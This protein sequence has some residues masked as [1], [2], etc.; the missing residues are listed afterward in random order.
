MIISLVVAGFHFDLLAHAGGF[1]RDEVNLINVASRP[2]LGQMSL[3]SFPVGMPLL[4]K[5]WT[6]LGLAQS[7]ANLRLLG[8][9]IGLAA[10]ASLWI[11]SFAVCRAPPL[12]SLT[13]FALN[14]N[15][16]IF[17]DSVRSYGLG[18]LLIVLTG[19]AACAVLKRP[20]WSRTA[21]LAVIAVLSVQALFHNAILVGAIC[22][23]AMTVC[24]RRRNCLAAVRI[25]VAGIAAAVSL[26]PYLPHLFSGHD[27]MAVLRVGSSWTDVTT[28]L[29]VAVGSPV[30]P[31]ACVWASL[32]VAV[33]AIA[34]AT[35]FQKSPN[36][37]QS[38]SNAE[39]RLF[40]G[41][42]S[43]AAIAG[44]LG[45]LWLTG[46]PEEPWYFI[47]LMVLLATG[48]DAVFATLPDKM[49]NAILTGAAITFLISL[50]IDWHQMNFRFTNV[51]TLATDVTAE[52]SPDDYVVITPWFYGITFA[53]YYQGATPWTTVP[54]MAD[55]STHR[56]DLLR[57]Q[58]LTTNAIQPILG[59]ITATLRNGHRV[60]FLYP[61]KVMAN[62][63]EGVS[64]PQILPPPPLPRIGWSPD[65][66]VAMWT[67]QVVFLLVN[68]GREIRIVDAKQS[69]S[70][71]TEDMDLLVI[72]GW[73]DTP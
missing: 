45:F 70:S 55:H 29:M 52:A 26:L 46:L 43:L 2:S 40:A 64:K 35:G 31:F 19:A 47:S 8:I 51:D 7:D 15:V 67:S 63:R 62:L 60:W 4:V 22:L 56:Y 34:A 72:N 24:A 18:A 68:N 58:M 41:T 38:I 44:L 57:E 17:G 65:P 1:W 9:F 11:A 53:H 59:K 5:S 13:L 6:G 25:A 66:Y 20:C 37:G 54:P 71:I 27:A 10:I 42:T 49:K 28:G 50:P 21:L 48:F 73:R 23:G 69:E 3:D 16:I 33:I 14:S 30:R 32:A 36:A 12:I 61:A 39:I